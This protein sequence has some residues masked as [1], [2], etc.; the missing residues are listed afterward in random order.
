MDK[1]K[2]KNKPNNVN[3]EI[4]NNDYNI[5]YQS[6]AVESRACKTRCYIN[7]Y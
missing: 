1:T 5:V 4:I 3:V 7:I 6:I 2:N